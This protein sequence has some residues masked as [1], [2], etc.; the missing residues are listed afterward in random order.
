MTDS[1]N[2]LTEADP[3]SLEELFSCDPETLTDGEISLMVDEF[4]QQREVWERA[5]IEG[6][7]KGRRKAAPK[8]KIDTS[9]LD[10][11]I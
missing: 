11:D 3:R 5:E 8:P 7:T 4:R 6:K 10:L 2:P 9:S 1:S